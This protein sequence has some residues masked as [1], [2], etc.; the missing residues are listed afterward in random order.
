MEG[1]EALT[2]RDMLPTQ[3]SVWMTFGPIIGGTMSGI[4]PRLFSAGNSETGAIPAGV[5]IVG[6]CIG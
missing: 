3:E 5:D 6:S 4:K 1:S 2:L